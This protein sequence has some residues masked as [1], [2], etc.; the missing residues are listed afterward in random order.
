MFSAVR[1][2]ISLRDR[3]KLGLCA[4][5]LLFSLSFGMINAQPVGALAPVGQEAGQVTTGTTDGTGVTDDT[6]SKPG[7]PKN[8]TQK[9]TTHCFTITDPS[10]WE[11]AT[12]ENPDADWVGGMVCY[13]YS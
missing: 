8:S 6:K 12:G 2:H 10:L 4:V 11:K 1:T 13:K 3:V 7:G 5:S 9:Q